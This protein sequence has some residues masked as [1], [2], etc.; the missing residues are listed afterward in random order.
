MRN[1]PFAY[2]LICL[3]ALI[4]VI[5]SIWEYRGWRKQEIT[6]YGQGWEQVKSLK[7]AET[8]VGP[9][10]NEKL[11]YRIRYPK[12]WQVTGDPKK[13][14]KFANPAIREV[15]IN[16]NMTESTQ[17]LVDIA[18][19]LAKSG[20]ARER[21]YLN[22]GEQSFQILTFANS[23]QIVQKA[24]TKKGQQIIIIQAQTPTKNWNEFEL[25]FKEVYKS[26][27]IF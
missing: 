18:D 13:I 11:R 14:I 24:L 2:L 23:Q 5:G 8:L 6:N 26:L 9:Y 16:I 15:A 22:A 1:L 17:S 25:T 3:F 21:E 10:V 20:L 27:V 12:N 19:N 7:E 4:G